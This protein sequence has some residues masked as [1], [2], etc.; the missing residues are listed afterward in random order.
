MKYLLL[1]ILILFMLI[2][3]VFF[4]GYPNDS[5]TTMLSIAFGL[6]CYLTWKGTKYERNN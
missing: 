4:C 3:Y 5:I 1:T 6:L 2:G